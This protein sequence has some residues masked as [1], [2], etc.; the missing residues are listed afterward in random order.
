MIKKT[1]YSEPGMTVTTIRFLGIT[2]YSVTENVR[3]CK[4][5]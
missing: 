3:L 1:I 2:I 5:K 4:S